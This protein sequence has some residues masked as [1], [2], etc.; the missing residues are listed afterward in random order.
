MDTKDIFD[1]ARGSALPKS[2]CKRDQQRQ[3]QQELRAVAQQC[4]ERVGYLFHRELINA[5]LFL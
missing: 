2:P 4:L 1:S 3:Q 5:M